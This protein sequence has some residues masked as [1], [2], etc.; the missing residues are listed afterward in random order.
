M[1]LH[2]VMNYLRTLDAICTETDLS[3]FVR[4]KLRP[5]SRM[6]EICDNHEIFMAFGRYDHVLF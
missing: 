3:V 4:K 6:S 5:V 1:R 2:A